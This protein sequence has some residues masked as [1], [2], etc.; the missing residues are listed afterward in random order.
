[1]P[2]CQAAKKK[3]HTDLQTFELH[4][5]ISLP[6]FRKFF[7]FRVTKVGKKSFVGVIHIVKCAKKLIG[8]INECIHVEPVRK[9]G[10]AFFS[11]F[12]TFV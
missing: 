6:L 3:G 11:V 5:H 10:N 2:V 4:D 9:S 8:G 1:M 7:I 12:S